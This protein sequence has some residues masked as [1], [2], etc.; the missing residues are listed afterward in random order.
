MAEQ[1]IEPA[2]IGKIDCDVGEGTVHRLWRPREEKVR[3]TTPYSAKFSVPYCV[4]VAFHDRAAGPRQFDSERIRDE[5]VLAL[6]AKVSY[7]VDPADEYPDNYTGRM[8][9]TLHDG[10]EHNAVQPHLRGGRRQP[11]SDRELAAKFFQNAANGGWS[12][13]RANDLRQY[14]ETLFERDNL[15]GL[16]TFR[17]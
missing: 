15:N 5:S 8:R 3:P 9:V 11:L 14:L 2:E 12:E 16:A 13:A 4:A 17:G 7:T 6:A 10:A 1:G